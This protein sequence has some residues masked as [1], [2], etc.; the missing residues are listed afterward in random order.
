MLL[1]ERDAGFE[2]TR[3]DPAV[4]TSDNF[5]IFA[6]RVAHM[7]SSH[8]GL[9]ALWRDRCHAM[10]RTAL[11]RKILDNLWQLIEA[12]P[13]EINS[14]ISEFGTPL[15]H[16]SGAGSKRQGRRCREVAE[17]LLEKGAS[18]NVDAGTCGSALDIASR[19]KN[20]ILQKVLNDAGA[21]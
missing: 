11:E 3:L 15:Q 4:H 21:Y 5:P 2:G 12:D 10:W 14:R 8:L 9:P 13:S 20:T 1:V 17:L 18:P 19:S 7:A 16:L 6:L